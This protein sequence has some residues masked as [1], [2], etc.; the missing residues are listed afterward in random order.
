[1]F[2]GYQAG[3]EGVPPYVEAQ[4]G[5][6]KWQRVI[7]DMGFPAGGA[8][9]MTADLTDKLPQ[10]TQRIR[11]STNLQIYWNSILIS[12]TQQDQNARLTAVPLARADLRFHGFPLK[13][14]NQPP[15][16]VRYV[17]EKASATG[18]YTRPVGTYTRYGDVRPLL[19][20]SDDRFVVLGS[21]DEVALDFDPSKLP[22]LPQGWVRDYFFQAAGYEKDMDFYAAEGNTVD[23]LPFHN[24]GTY[25][26]P[27]GKLFPLDDAHLNYMLDYNT[28]YMSGNE[29]RG[30]RFDYGPAK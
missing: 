18:P 13:I 9:T 14:E 15:G 19:T 10:G 3:V 4:D 17:Y 29:P 21:G 23:P 12:R 24:M 8:R 28:R 2:A 6:G 20:A 27:A 26:Y 30:Y 16:N 5:S 25:P 7:D 1:M 11:I 22:A